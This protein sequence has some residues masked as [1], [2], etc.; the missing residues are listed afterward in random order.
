MKTRE[1]IQ[2]NYYWPGMIWDINKYVDGCPICPK[3]KPV[4]DKPIGELKPTEIPKQPW[5]IIAVDFVRELPES[6]GKNCIMNV[7]DRHSKLLY[8]G[9]CNTK[10]SAEGA[11]KLFLETA[12]QYEGL[13]RQVISDRG[14]QFAAAFTKELNRLLRIKGSLTTAYHPQSDGQTERVNQE[15]EIYL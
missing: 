13:P 6:A 9:A 2:Q 11:A 14:P 12:W 4:R 1:L 5:D 15:M 8:S 7:I 10:I 3:V